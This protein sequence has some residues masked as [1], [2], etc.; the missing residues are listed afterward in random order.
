MDWTTVEHLVYLLIA[1]PLTLWV[2]RSMSHNGSIFLRDVF[3]KGDVAEA[4]NQLLLVGFYLLNL[5][6]VLLWLQVGTTG[7]GLAALIESLSAKVGV[8]M[9]GIG[10]AHL[11]NVSVFSKIRRRGT[12]PAPQAP[13][14]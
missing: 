12:S 1:V 8:V 13:T 4:T 10:A 3:E 7:A 11:F 14:H 5:G 6:F 2:G 9:L